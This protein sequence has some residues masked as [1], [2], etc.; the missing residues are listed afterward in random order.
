[1]WLPLT[2][3]L[4]LTYNGNLQITLHWSLWCSSLVYN[5]KHEKSLGQVLNI[6]DSQIMYGK[7]LGMGPWTCTI[8]LW[9]LLRG[10]YQNTSNVLDHLI[11]CLFD[12]C[13]FF[14]FSQPIKGKDS[15]AS[16]TLTHKSNSIRWQLY[17]ST[18]ILIL[19]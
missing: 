15:C 8:F 3:L 4:F 14:F 1:M 11:F 7:C 10:V 16:V 9:L 17:R 13:F 6:C 2:A 19:I 18:N 5:T 12:Q